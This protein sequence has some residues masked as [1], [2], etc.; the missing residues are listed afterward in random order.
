LSSACAGQCWV[1]GYVDGQVALWRTDPGDPARETTLPAAP[2]D[3]D[4]PGPRTIIVGGRPGVL[5][6]HAGASRLLLQNGSGWRTLTAPDGPVRDAVVIGHRLYAIVG[7]DL[8]S[9][10][11]L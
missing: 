1:S 10:E 3:V 6:S 4:G 7:A 8:W 11:L 9:A 5:F 2:I